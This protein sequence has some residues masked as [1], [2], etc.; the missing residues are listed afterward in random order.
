M[1]L[2]PHADSDVLVSGS[3]LTVLISLCPVVQTLSQRKNVDR[4]LWIVIG[5]LLRLG[6]RHC[7]VANAFLDWT[8]RTVNILVK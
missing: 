2:E 7:Q 3:R 8:R 1:G 4:L 5:A 6:R